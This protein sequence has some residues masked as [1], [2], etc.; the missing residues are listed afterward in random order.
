MPPV[1]VSQLIFIDPVVKL[2]SIETA[3]AAPQR[4]VVC[5]IQHVDRVELQPSGSLKMISQTAGM[6]SFGASGLTQS[7]A[8]KPEIHDIWQTH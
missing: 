8:M 3:K 4:E 6:Q 1:L 7:L 5:T 2:R